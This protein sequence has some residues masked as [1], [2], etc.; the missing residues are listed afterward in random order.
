M[1]NK[2][3]TLEIP[4]RLA[5]E[6]GDMNQARVRIRKLYLETMENLPTGAG[7]FMKEGHMM[8]LLSQ[9]KVA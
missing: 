2:L 7:C 5:V 6:A 8:Q 1:T 4:L 9:I 3:Y